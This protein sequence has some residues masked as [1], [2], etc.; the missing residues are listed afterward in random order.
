MTVEGLKKHFEDTYK[1][2]VSMITNGSCIVFS[3]YDQMAKKRLP[4]KIPEAVESVTKKEIPNFRKFL[5][6]SVSGNNAEGIDCMLP[7]V[8]Y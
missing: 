5:A 8:R 2:E 7:D 3:A 4:M 6:L 1:I